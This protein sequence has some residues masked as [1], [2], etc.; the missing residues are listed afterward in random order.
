MWLFN[1]SS[2]PKQVLEI[3]SLNVNFNWS[4]LGNDLIKFKI[5]HIKYNCKNFKKY[6]KWQ[7]FE[8]IKILRA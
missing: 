5:K 6:I 7:D 3:L 2:I 8:E 4:P 1:F